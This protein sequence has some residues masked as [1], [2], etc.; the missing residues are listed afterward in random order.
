[1]GNLRCGCS[2]TEES[3][4][5][6]QRSQPCKSTEK[7]SESLMH[8]VIFCTMDNGMQWKAWMLIFFHKLMTLSGGKDNVN[9]GTGST[10]DYGSSTASYESDVLHVNTVD[11][12]IEESMITKEN[13]C[14]TAGNRD[15]LN[16]SNYIQLFNSGHKLIENTVEYEKILFE[17]HGC[18]IYQFHRL[19]LVDNNCIEAEF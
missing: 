14:W 5:T 15:I 3:E 19:Q 9:G 6:Q 8:P 2:T 17:T 18:S 7:V 4:T 11:N 13:C 10:K 12:N 1:M 16:N